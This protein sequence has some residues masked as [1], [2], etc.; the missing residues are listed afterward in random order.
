MS[1]SQ[2]LVLPDDTPRPHHSIE[3]EVNRDLECNPEGCSPAL[4]S[5]QSYPSK[6]RYPKGLE[7]VFLTILG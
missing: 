7:T 4:G 5:W 2:A 3:K 1:L 6:H